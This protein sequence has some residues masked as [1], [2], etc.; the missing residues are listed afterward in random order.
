MNLDSVHAS[1]EKLASPGGSSCS[2][3]RTAPVFVLG[4]PRSGTTVLYH[5]ILSAGDFAVYRA[6]SNVFNLL[7]PRFGGMKSSSDRKQ[8]MET[9]R[10]SVLF[11]VSGLDGSAIEN[12]ILQECRSEGDFLRILMQ[13]IASAQ[14]VA[15]WADCTP[16]HLLYMEEIKKQLPDALFIHIIR[17][18]RDVALSYA[19]QGWVHPLPWDRGRELEIA[20]LYWE[21][22]VRKGREQGA[23]LG[24]D[25]CEVRYERLVAEPQ[26]VLSNLGAFIA[27]D[28]DYQKIQ[29]AGIG[30]VSRP[31]SSFGG[32][33]EGTFNPV[34]RWKTKMS[35]GEIAAFENLVGDFLNELDYPLASGSV[36][37]GSLHAARLKATYMSLFEA[38]HWAKTHT[39]LGRRTRLERIEIQPSP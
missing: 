37:S 7:G 8:L 25:Y 27:H 38:K 34:G 16:E 1:D 9:W 36:R 30:S 12:R 31:N 20:G 6:E 11:R 35:A 26:E 10:Q 24:A 3:R 17:D 23:R 19:R 32:D 29:S 14:G 13:S 15:R 33:G 22:L 39:P 4:C 28:L 2:S 21:W 5:M 18:G